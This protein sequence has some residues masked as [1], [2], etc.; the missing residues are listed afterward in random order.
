MEYE[1]FSVNIPKDLIVLQYEH[2]DYLDL[3]LDPHKI[4]GKKQKVDKAIAAV[5]KIFLKNGWEGDGNI[6]LIWIPPFLDQSNDDN[7]GNLVWHVKQSNNG[8][9]F[10][11][12]YKPIQSAKLLDQ[13]PVF[14]KEG[15]DVK[16][17]SLIYTEEKNLLLQ[18][19]KKK[20]LLQ[21]VIEHIK[22]GTLSDHLINLILGYIQNG[23]ISEFNDFIDE[24]YLRYLVHV[25]SHNNPDS[26]NLKKR[27]SWIGLDQISEK[28]NEGL[29]GHW[30]TIHQI[31][32]NI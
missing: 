17:I 32:G 7:Y 11:G 9:S 2:I 14:K 27:S 19:K 5:K 18:L 25:L 20:K 22:S 10:L 30:L 6:G 1:L 13:N 29:G 12:F 28:M 4:Y 24:C 16:P 15:R 8:T 3:S 26:I 23:A 21:E 31:I